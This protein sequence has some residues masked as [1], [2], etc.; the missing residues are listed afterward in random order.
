MLISRDHAQMHG[1]PSR[2]LWTT[3][4]IAW[5]C[6]LH[7][8]IR[9]RLRRR[10]L[11]CDDNSKRPSTSPLT[12]SFQG[13]Q[14][15]GHRTRCPATAQGP[16]HA[17]GEDATTH[18]QTQDRLGSCCVAIELRSTAP[19]N[20]PSDGELSRPPA[21]SSECGAK[22]GGGGAL[23]GNLLVAGNLTDLRAA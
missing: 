9:K 7:I 22:E 11:R 1:D 14:C 16:R 17:P 15:N 23:G 4:A 13:C 5:S 20:T 10:P 12:L 21:A 19:H 6:A 3:D 2:R 18:P 8:T